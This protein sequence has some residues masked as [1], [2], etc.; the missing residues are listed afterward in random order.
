[1]WRITGLKQFLIFHAI[2]MPP[3]AVRRLLYDD[4]IKVKGV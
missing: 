3:T 2:S 4:L 1:M